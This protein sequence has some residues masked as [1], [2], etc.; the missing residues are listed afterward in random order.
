MVFVPGGAYPIGSDPD[1]D[2]EAE[3]EEYPRH[4]VELA[5]FFLDRLQVTHA[6]WAEAVRAGAVRP[7]PVIREAPLDRHGWPDGQMPAALADHP[8]CLVLEDEAEAYCRF[9]GKRLPTEAEWE[10]AA[11]GPEGRRFAWGDTFDPAR[12]NTLEARVGTTVPV[13]SFP[14][15]AGPFGTLDQGCNVSEWVVGRFSS[16]PRVRQLDNRDD[17]VDHFGGTDRVMRGASYESAWRK[18]RAASRWV[19]TD[20]R[21]LVGFRCAEDVDGGTP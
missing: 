8:V 18:A 3:T 1:Q 9:R 20:E 16:Y 12:C 21:K 10:A 2:P 15:N 17:W 5:P 19:A 14:S 7:P 6:Q 11:R 13:G 4:L